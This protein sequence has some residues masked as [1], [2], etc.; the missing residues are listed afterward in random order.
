MFYLFVG[1]NIMG[2]GKGFW[3]GFSYFSGGACLFAGAIEI[4]F[5]MGCARSE[6]ADEDMRKATEAQAARDAANAPP[7]AATDTPK[8]GWFGGAKTANVGG[9]GGEP[10]ISVNITPSQAAQGAQWA[11]NNAGTVAAVAN[12]A[13]PSAAGSSNPFFGN[14]HLGNQR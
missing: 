13:A 5:G 6:Q 11:A 14:S 7:A 8:R 9:G 2:T 3:K 4:M 10:T 1:T 12:A